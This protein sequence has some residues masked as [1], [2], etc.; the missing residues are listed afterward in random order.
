MKFRTCIKIRH[1]R[2]TKILLQSEVTIW[3][4]NKLVR[5]EVNYLHYRNVVTVKR[6]NRD[7]HRVVIKSI[8]SV[9]HGTSYIVQAFLLTKN[10]M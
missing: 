10:P 2:P 1:V 6:S 9:N 5:W 8:Y 4:K 7:N 3:G